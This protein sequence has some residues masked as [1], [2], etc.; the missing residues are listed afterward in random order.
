MESPAFEVTISGMHALSLPPSIVEPFLEKGH[1]RV[2]VVATHGD[3]T[4]SF[5]GAIQKRGEG[6]FM[7]FGKQNQ[8]ALGVFPNDYFQLQLFE[9]TSK[10]GVEMPEEFQVVLE[11]DPEAL[12]HFES[13]TDGRKR[14]LIYTIL[15]YKNSQTRIDKAL[16]LCE[17]L[18]RGVQ[19][20]RHLFKSF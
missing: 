16:I 6:Y 17:N 12:E 10:Y 7:M 9:D 11:S 14:G 3:E 8:K 5:H 13:L 1:S 15:R 19:D 18:K 2:K 4:I 20:P